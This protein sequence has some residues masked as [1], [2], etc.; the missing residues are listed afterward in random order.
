MVSREPCDGNPDRR[1]RLLVRAAA[2]GSRTR[3]DSA[4]PRTANGPGS[5]HACT[6]RSC[7]SWKRSCDLAGLAPQRMIFG[8]DAAHEA[9]DQPPAGDVVEHREFFRDDQRIVEQRQRAAEHR[10]LGLLGAARERAGHH[11][12]RRHQAVGGLV[13]LVDA[14]HRRSR[15]ASANSSSSR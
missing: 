3:S 4:C 9:R 6:I 8:A 7:A 2:T 14:E 1:M 11:A 12:G 13:M 5:V 15:A 10:D